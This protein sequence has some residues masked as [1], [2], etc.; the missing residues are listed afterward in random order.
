MNTKR[1]IEV[2]VAWSCGVALGSIYVGLL[3]YPTEAAA[4][5]DVTT[6]WVEP[7]MNLI[8]LMV[9]VMALG[10]IGLAYQTYQ[11]VHDDG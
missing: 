8:T 7:A 3:A 11:D 10:T 4:L 9:A 5:T 6:P 1:I 2:G